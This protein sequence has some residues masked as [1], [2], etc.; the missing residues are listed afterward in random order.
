MCLENFYTYISNTVCENWV[1]LMYSRA[2]Y[3]IGV[4]SIFASCLCD[5][6]NLKN[7]L[8]RLRS[9]LSSL[10]ILYNKYICT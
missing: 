2:E 8:S 3:E 10:T 4:G 6:Y 1:T 9:S 5:G 7:V